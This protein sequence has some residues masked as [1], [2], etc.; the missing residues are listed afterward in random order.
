MA[1]VVD[2]ERKYRQEY[3]IDFMFKEDFTFKS[4]KHIGR[5]EDEMTEMMYESLMI[6]PPNMID[7]YLTLTGSSF[8]RMGKFEAGEEY[9]IDFEYDFTVSGTIEYEN[10]TWDDPGWSE[11]H[12]ERVKDYKEVDEARILR[13][14]KDFF[15]DAL[16]EKSI[17]C[18][19]SDV[20]EV[21]SYISGW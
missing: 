1:R 14:L 6:D 12:F 11:E 17:K 5:F 2:A 21:D 4:L 16:I 18:R 7:H 10:T 8:D 9:G 15:G 13:Y 20:K 3:S 19:V